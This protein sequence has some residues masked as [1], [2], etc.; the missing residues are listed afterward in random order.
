MQF[1]Y[2]ARASFTMLRHPGEGIE[3]VRGRIDRRRD[4]RELTAL[5]RPPSEHYAAVTDWAPVLHKA[6]G[7][8][9]PC[10]ESEQFGTVW[11]ATVSRLAAAGLR[12]GLA[13][14]RGWNDG[15]RAQAEAIWCLVAHSRPGTVVETGVAHGLTSRVIL[16]GLHRNGDGH[17]WSVDLP[18][19]DPALHHE[20]GA[21]VPED[22]RSRWTYVEGTSRR[23]LP[24]LVRG[25]QQVDLFVHDSLHTAR[26]TCFE[27]DTV[28]PALPPGGVAVVDDIDHSLGFGRFTE[29]VAPA[30]W[31]AARHVT[32]SGLWGT[33]VKAGARA[34]P[35]PGAQARRLPGVVH[36]TRERRHE[37]IEDGVVGEIGRM[38]K[39][40]APENSRLLQIQP[41][42]GRQTLLF[43]DQLA[44]PCRPVIYAGEDTRDPAVSAATDFRQVDVEAAAFP[45]ADG[46]FDLV[47]W[48]RDL[49]TVKN[50]RPA[51]RE[52]RRVLRPGGVLVVAV[53]NLA[54]LHNRLLLLAGRQPTTLHIGNGDHVRGFAVRSMTGFLTRDLGLE[55]LRVTGVGLAPVSA[56]VL[57]AP[58]RGISHTV[59][60]ALRKPQPDLAATDPAPA[61]HT[62]ASSDTGPSII[63]PSP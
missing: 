27:L 12:V 56:A 20:I 11:D 55:L 30:D 45:A 50:L 33:A 49:V 6:I 34:Q 62:R 21:A 36:V 57:P 54:A 46:D 43:R 8:P 47:I 2:T 32:G 13:S 35:R 22:L 16:E 59:V 18:S 10:Q 41:G 51:L 53:P 9:W 7:V 40:L 61:K 1:G 31:I 24:G 39:A 28:W 17:L 26:N 25:L 14:Y 15:D 48:N 37:R 19:V 3:R 23:R 63:Q 58:V 38:I 44:V 52:A 4:Q 5:S 60:W 29:R 42:P